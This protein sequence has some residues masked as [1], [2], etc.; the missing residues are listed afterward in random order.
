MGVLSKKIKNVY[1]YDFESHRD[2]FS[3]P[4]LKVPPQ[5]QWKA[6]LRGY[7]FVNNNVLMDKTTYCGTERLMPR[8]ALG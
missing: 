5:K 4:K 6:L 8:H 7:I 1:R 3:W 2:S